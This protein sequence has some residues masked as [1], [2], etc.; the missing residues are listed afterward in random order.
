[1][2][3]RPKGGGRGDL[4]GGGGGGGGRGGG[5][6][7]GVRRRSWAAGVVEVDRQ[8]GESRGGWPNWKLSQGGRRGFVPRRG[9]G[10]VVRLLRPVGL[11]SGS[12]AGASLPVRQ[13]P[14]S[15]GAQQHSGRGP[16][17]AVLIYHECRARI[18][19]RRLVLALHGSRTT[20]SGGRL[21]G[22]GA[23]AAA[24]ASRLS[25]SSPTCGALLRLVLVQIDG[26]GQKLNLL[27]HL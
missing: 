25:A 27:H 9:L 19:H 14:G 20:A 5:G 26:G 23:G 11:Q 13:K 12:E 2:R 22:G 17:A 21:A 7:G 8:R 18:R 10:V 1:M 4:D 6:G 3:L 16:P 15:H 24:V